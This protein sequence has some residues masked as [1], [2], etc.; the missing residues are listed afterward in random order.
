MHPQETKHVKPPLKGSPTKH[1]LP[2]THDYPPAALV[3]PPVGPWAKGSVCDPILAAPSTQ[4]YP[5]TPQPMHRSK[6]KP[7]FC[8]GSCAVV[9]G[10]YL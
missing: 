5:R 8:G 9:M 2:S 10:R 4:T 3:P 6:T 1:H 7:G